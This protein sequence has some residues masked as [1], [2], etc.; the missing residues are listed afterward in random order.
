MTSQS[1]DGIVGTARAL[2]ADDKGLLAMDESTGTCDARF[3]R[4]GIPQTEKSRRAYRELILTTRGLGEFI[5]G[6]ILSDETIRQRRS[7]DVMFVQAAVEGG[8]VP[9]I[10]VDLGA[11]D[12]AGRRGE[13]V[14]EGLDGLRVR[15]GEYSKMGARLAKWRGIIAIGRA[16]PPTAASTPMRTLSRGMRRCARKQ[17]WFRLSNPRFSWTAIMGWS[18]AAR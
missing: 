10:K 13:K 9:G 11:K 5:S 7:D 15:L 1:V 4:W 12:L 18:S 6:V 16:C 17:A 8:M 14:T 2:V 3:A